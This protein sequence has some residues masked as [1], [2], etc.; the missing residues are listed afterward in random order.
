MNLS[1]PA[2]IVDAL[3]VAATSLPSVFPAVQLRGPS[4]EAGEYIDGAILVADSAH[5]AF[6]QSLAPLGRAGSRHLLQ[7]RSQPEPICG[8]ESILRLGGMLLHFILCLQEQRSKPYHRLYRQPVSGSVGQWGRGRHF[9]SR[10]FGSGAGLLGQLGGDGG[11]PH[12]HRRGFCNHTHG[13]DLPEP[14]HL[15]TPSPPARASLFPHTLQL[16][17]VPASSQS[18]TPIGAHRR[19]ATWCLRVFEAS[20]PAVSN[21]Q[22]RTDRDC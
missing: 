14:G 10:A 5:L 2:L 12:H 6:F 9:P 15:P 19:V 13:R 17:G 20:I 22:T 21:S 3:I 4:K 7:G 16:Y 18:L 1:V 8:H 11:R